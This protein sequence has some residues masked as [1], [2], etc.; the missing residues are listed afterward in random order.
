M[1]RNLVNRQVV[2]RDRFH[3]PE[4]IE[5]NDLAWLVSNRNILR[6]IKRCRLLWK[7]KATPTEIYHIPGAVLARNHMHRSPRADYHIYILPLA[8]RSGHDK[9]GI[10]TP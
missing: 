5:E 4:R 10:E 9:I 3:A 8:K 1:M 6:K 2:M 7:A